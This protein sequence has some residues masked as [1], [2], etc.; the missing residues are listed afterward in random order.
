MMMKRIT[1]PNLAGLAVLACL[2]LAGSASIL[3]GQADQ[4]PDGAKAFLLGAYLKTQTVIERTEADLEKVKRDIQ[5]DDGLIRKL[6]N[7]RSRARQ[8]NDARAEK[9]A[10]ETLRTARAAGTKNEETWAALERLRARSIASRDAL[11]GRIDALGR[12]PGPDPQL[13]GLV[14]D[15]SGSVRIAKKSGEIIDPASGGPVFLETGDAITTGPGGRAELQTLGGRAVVRLGGESEIRLA[16]DTVDKQAMELVKGRMYS[17]VDKPE[18]L[19]A[20]L[21]GP[22]PGRHFEEPGSLD[23]LTEKLLR[24]LR[25]LARK[26]FEVIHSPTVGSIRGTRFSFEVKSDGGTELAVYEGEVELRNIVNGKTVIVGQGFKAT[27]AQDGISE[28]LKMET[29]DAWWEKQPGTVR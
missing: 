17:A 29:I 18:E 16:G 22:K 1:K 9:A 25:R 11:R 14:S 7:I 28:P 24:P 20:R 21:S 6:E 10:E 12:T 5:A 3:R 13:R 23:K 19:E 8:A 26:W 27:A 4:D 15:L 2:L